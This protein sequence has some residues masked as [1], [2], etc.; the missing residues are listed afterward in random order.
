MLYSVL[1]SKQKQLH[2]HKSNK[3][4]ES[5]LSWIG[6]FEEKIDLSHI[7]LAV[8]VKNNPT[9]LDLTICKNEIWNSLSDPVNS[10]E[11]WKLEIDFKTELKVEYFLQN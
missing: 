5:T 8:P 3:M 7:Y 2:G 1:N 10:L 6:N 4:R 9:L 11:P